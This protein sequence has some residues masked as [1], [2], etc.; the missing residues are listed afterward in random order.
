MKIKKIWDINYIP[1]NKVENLARKAGIL[2]LQA[3]VFL[4]RGID[5]VE[6]I[7]KFFNPTLE[8][9]NDPFLLK[10]MNLAVGRVIQAVKKK[11]K[12]LIYGDYDVDGVTSTS[13]LYK[14]LKE[15]NADVGYYIPDRFNEGYGF[16]KSSVKKIINM[17]VDL[18]ITVDCGTTALKESRDLSKEGIDMV[19][20]DHHE[21]KEQLPIVS[22]LVNPQRPDCLYPN[23]NLSGVGVAFKLVKGLSIEMNV[24]IKQLP[25]LA[26]VALG[27]VAD[28]LP[29]TGENRVLVKFGIGEINKTSNIGLKSLMNEVGILDRKVT[30]SDIGYILAPRINAAGRMGN[31]A[32]AVELLTTDN[33]VVAKEIASK[34]NKQNKQRQEIEKKIFEEVVGKIEKEINIKKSYVM[35][36]SGE[37]W[38]QGVIGIVASKITEKYNKPCVLIS[39]SEGIGKGSARS[40]EGLNLFNALVFCER[41]LEKFGGHEMAAGLTVREDKINEFIKLINQYA[42]SFIDVHSYIQ[43]IK[44]DTI[45]KSGE[46][47]L[48]NAR[49]LSLLEPFGIDN[50]EPLFKF[51]NAKIVEISAVGN[52]NSHLKLKIENNNIKIDAIAFNKGELINKYKRADIIDIACILDINSWQGRECVQ[53][54]VEDIKPASEIVLKNKFFSSLDKCL[55]FEEKVVE[56]NLIKKVSSIEEEK[57]LKEYI[58]NYNLQREKV[59]II[60]NSMESIKEI[61]SLVRNC[62]FEFD[63]QY[64]INFSDVKTNNS[65][66]YLLVNPNTDKLKMLN[67]KKIIIYGQWFCENYLNKVLNNIDLNNVYI[68]NKINFNFNKE[69][70]IPNRQDMAFVYKYLKINYNKKFVLESL[71][72]FSDCISKKYGIDMNYFKA[73]KIIQIFHQLSFLK[74]KPYGKDG[75]TI[76]MFDMGKEKRNIEDSFLYRSISTLRG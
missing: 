18:V 65:S 8:D 25:L 66:V 61:M 6:V 45:I 70:I 7:N 16:S 27:T 64:S 14:F 37:K 20:T 76:K 30:T 47:T 54:K 52:A 56:R 53:L 62:A 1:F 51:E 50:P 71:F 2:N 28:V 11:E 35:V 67:F 3:K 29:L 49:Q 69:S 22:A 15:Q 31:S 19:I 48:E 72:T 59:L 38:H 41:T 34:L 13:I 60:L 68:Y 24:E 57:D 32:V 26:L 36:V 17:Q 55:D 74:S 43:K 4:S 44:I 63:L 12:I 33:Q 42:S 73:K 75:M 40:I 21:C 58:Y 39:I 10:D 23:K 9:L 46:V 5:N